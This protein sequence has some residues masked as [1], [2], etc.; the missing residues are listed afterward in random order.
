MMITYS[1][2]YS[3]SL[4]V[5]REMSRLGI[6]ILSFNFHTKCILVTLLL[7]LYYIGGLGGTIYKGQEAG[8]F[9]EGVDLNSVTICMREPTIS[10]L[11]EC[12]LKEQ[13]ILI[14]SPPM[15]G[16]TSLGQLFEDKLLKLDEVQNGS[17]WVFVCHWYGC[18]SILVHGHFRKNLKGL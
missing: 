16:K 6:K 12:L 18:K 9:Y 7:I 4:T 8:S 14:R 17:A 10:N 5:V 1:I 15:T 13:I 2:S 3:L 11:L